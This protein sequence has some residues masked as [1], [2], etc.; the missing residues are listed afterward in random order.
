MIRPPVDIPRAAFPA[1]QRQ[2]IEAAAGA[3]PLDHVPR[4]EQA[5]TAAAPASYPEQRPVPHQIADG[6]DIHCAHASNMA[7]VRR[8]V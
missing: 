4:I 1:D 7:A 2:S 3:E 8:R 5:S 6:F